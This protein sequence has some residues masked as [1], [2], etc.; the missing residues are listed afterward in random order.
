M[1]EKELKRVRERMVQEKKA[2]KH[3]HWNKGGCNEQG[4]KKTSKGKE[5]LSSR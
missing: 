1:T 5:S 3:R 4:H 2:L